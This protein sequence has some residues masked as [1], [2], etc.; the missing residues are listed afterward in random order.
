MNPALLADA[1]LLLHGLF[2]LFVVFGAALAVWRWRLRWLHL[3]ALAWGSW[4]LASGGICPL[5]PLENRLRLQAGE[6]GY[7]GSFID[8]YLMPLIYPEGLE[9]L[10]GLFGALLLGINLGLYLWAWRRHHRRHDAG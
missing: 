2:I 7:S 5:T 6:A 8:H 9:Q 4:I 3:P 1:V 10:Q